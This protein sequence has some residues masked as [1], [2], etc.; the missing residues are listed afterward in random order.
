MPSYYETPGLAALEGGLEGSNV[1]ITRIGGTREYFGEL[2][3]YLNPYSIESIRKALVRAY[4]RPR[5]DKLQK[6]ILKNFTWDL[7]AKKTI[8]AYKSVL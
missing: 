3:D 7:A 6:R 2:A 1:V 5:S 4:D 8:E